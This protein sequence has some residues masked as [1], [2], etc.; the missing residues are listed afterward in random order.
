MPN[1]TGERIATADYDYELPK[2]LIAQSPLSNREDA[3]LMLAN[4]DHNM[5]DHYHVRDLGDVLQ[6]GDCFCLL[7]TSPS[8]RDRG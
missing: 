5:I 3:R 7:Y 4:R 1:D 2:D 6:A 8:P